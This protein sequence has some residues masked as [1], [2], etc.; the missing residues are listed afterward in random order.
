MLRFTYVLSFLLF[1]LVTFAQSTSSETE[2]QETTAV[3]KAKIPN[4][5]LPS[6][7]GIS[8][9]INAGTF[10][11]YAFDPTRLGLEGTLRYGFKKSWYAMLEAGYEKV[12]FDKPKYAYQSTAT[13]MRAG[14]DYNFFHPDEV[15]N[16]DNIFVGFRYGGSIINYE[17][18]RY[19]IEEGFWGDYIGSTPTTQAIGHWG[20]FVFGMRTEVL[21]NVYMGWSIR[22]RHLFLIQGED[23]LKPYSVPGY[24][25]TDN[26]TNLGF[27]YNLEYTI[28]FNQKKK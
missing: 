5:D 28:P 10:I 15:G 17:S 22:L 2:V 21:K 19:T 9:G 6:N 16:R 4:E 14:L 1:G 24:G 8:L 3:K 20:E 11:V 25:L 13:F 27:T 26:K 18:P 12:D 23:V 7:N